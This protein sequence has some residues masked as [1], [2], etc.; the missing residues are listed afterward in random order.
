MN[1]ARVAYIM[2]RFPH[3]PETFILREMIEL[4]RRGW[5]ITVYPLILQKQMVRHG[6]VESL[7]S[8]TKYIP[9]LSP[10][11]IK[12]NLRTLFKDPI[13]YVTTFLLSLYK[14]LPSPKFL[15]RA[16]V[17]FPKSV[18]LAESM[19][20]DRI[21]HIHAHYATHPALAAWI[22]NRF[23]GIPYSITAHAH[24]LYV[25]Q[26][27][28]DIKVRD[29]AFVVTISEFNKNFICKTVGEWARA[30][31]FV[32]HCGIRPEDYS[33]VKKSGNRFEI[34]SIGSLQPY[35]GHYVLINACALLRDR[36][37]E[38]SCKIIGGGE[39]M[40]KLNQQIS[41]LKLNGMV[42]LLGPLPQETV[43]TLLPGADCY[44]QPSVITSSGKMEGIPVALMEALACSLPVIATNISG[45]PELVKPGVT[46]ILVEPGD[47]VS[48][49]NAIEKI[50][51]DPENAKR[52]ADAGRDLVLSDFTITTNIDKLSL[53]FAKE[54]QK[55]IA[56]NLSLREPIVFSSPKL[57]E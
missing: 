41:S 12:A 33:A 13:K 9:Y 29:A 52:M 6:D 42:E 39:L 7:L 19:Q 3:L 34:I 57:E 55:S 15:L 38:F 49:A 23:S 37:L 16:L 27:M 30:K 4:R 32:I 47:E 20:K 43:A 46:G 45:V 54:K 5:D 31:I 48:L 14:N 11:T 53:L 25:E 28:L 36:G 10:K 56:P 51:S 24:D 22:I 40:E 21:E 44:V 50:Y 17:L 35:K 26:P 1:Q 18:A 2:S 8:V